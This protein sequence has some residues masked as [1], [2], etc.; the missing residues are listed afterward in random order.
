MVKVFYLNKENSE[1]WV[2][3]TFPTLN[4]KRMLSGEVSTCRLGPEGNRKQDIHTFPSATIF[5]QVVKA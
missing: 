2:N 1:Y 4:C 5:L 3:V